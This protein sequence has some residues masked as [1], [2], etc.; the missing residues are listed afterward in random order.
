MASIAGVFYGL[1]WRDRKC[2]LTSTVTHT[3]VNVGWLLLFR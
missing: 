2:V 3:L 1:A